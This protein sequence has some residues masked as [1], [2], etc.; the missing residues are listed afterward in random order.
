[1]SV[2]CIDHT[3]KHSKAGRLTRLSSR[4]SSAAD[5]PTIGSWQVSH[6][7]TH[8]RTDFRQKAALQGGVCV[9]TERPHIVKPT[10]LWKR[11]QET[12]LQSVLRP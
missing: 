10:R 7:L 3:D 4:R 12:I 11:K 6:C 1:M 2:H 8:Q 9:C 5:R